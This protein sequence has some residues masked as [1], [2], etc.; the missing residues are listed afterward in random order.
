MISSPG[1]L[2]F[3]GYSLFFRKFKTCS[4]VIQRCISVM[5]NPGVT[6]NIHVN[7]R[8]SLMD[9][10]VKICLSGLEAGQAVTLHASV[11]GDANE[12]FESHAHYVADKDGKKYAICT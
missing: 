11:V 2:Q 3:V 6:P 7:P 9:R 8:V 12:I 5:S 4:K 10:K 1:H